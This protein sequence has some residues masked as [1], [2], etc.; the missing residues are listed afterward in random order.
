MSLKIHINMMPADLEVRVADHM[1]LG[2][3][4]EKKAPIPF[5]GVVLQHVGSGLAMGYSMDADTAK[6]IHQHLT[7]AIKELEEKKNAQRID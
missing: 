2:V 4:S 1:H 5:I 3:M 7:W 6:S